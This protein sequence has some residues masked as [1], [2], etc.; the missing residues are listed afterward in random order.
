MFRLKN[1]GLLPHVD[2]PNL[3]HENYAN[4]ESFH[5]AVLGLYL[6]NIEQPRGEYKALL[7]YLDLLLEFYEVTNHNSSVLRINN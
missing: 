1:V 2:F 7:S 3:N 6:V 4:G 5:T